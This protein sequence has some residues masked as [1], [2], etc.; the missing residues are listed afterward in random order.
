MA[1][2]LLH[3]HKSGKLTA[4]PRRQAFIE[5]ITVDMN[6]AGAYAHE[7]SSFEEL[8]RSAD[9]AWRGENLPKM[10]ELDRKLCCPERLPAVPL[11]EG[12][13]GELRSYQRSGFDWFAFRRLFRGLDAPVM[14]PE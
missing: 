6:G 11:P 13:V 14:E 7:L 8:S 10:L 2:V 9:L 3:A 4:P 5:T 1:A 12:F